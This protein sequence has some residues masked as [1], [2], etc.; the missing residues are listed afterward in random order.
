[1][2]AYMYA[3]TEANRNLLEEDAEVGSLA[4]TLFKNPAFVAESEKLGY[5]NAMHEKTESARRM[6]R[7]G[8]SIED[9]AYAL[10]LSLAQVK[11]IKRALDKEAEAEQ[12]AAALP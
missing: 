8:D 2:G 6:L 10:D 9:V 12:Q 3:V 4:K 5:V 7:R 1:M 11:K